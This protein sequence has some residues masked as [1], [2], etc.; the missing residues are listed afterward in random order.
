MAIHVNSVLQENV[1][2]R[3]T[4]PSW[5]VKTLYLVTDKL[6]NTVVYIKVCQFNYEGQSVINNTF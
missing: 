6:S 1:L 4:G 5:C 2:K 3:I